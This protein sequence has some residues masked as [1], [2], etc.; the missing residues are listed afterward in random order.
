MCQCNKLR[1]TEFYVHC[2]DFFVLKRMIYMAAYSY[3][4]INNTY[5]NS[6]KNQFMHMS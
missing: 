2:L 5:P 6:C 3:I 1:K 4:H